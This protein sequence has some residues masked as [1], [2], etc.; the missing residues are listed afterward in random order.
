MKD[1]RLGRSIDF[2]ILFSPHVA[3]DLVAAGMPSPDVARFLAPETDA[4]EKWRML[5]PYWPLIRFTGYAQA[6]QRAARD[7]YQVPEISGQTHAALTEALR[8]GNRPG[9]YR[10]ILQ[11]QAGIDLCL[12]HPLD[13]R[14][15]VFR[16][17]ADGRLFR[18]DLGVDAFLANAMPVEEL[19]RQ[20][21]L[22]VSSLRELLRVIDWCFARYGDRAVAI[23]TRCA[24]WRTLRFDDVSQGQAETLFERGY[25]AQEGLSSSETKALQDFLFHCCI[26]RAGDYRLPV[27]IHTGYPGGNNRVDMTRIRATDLV[28][29]LPQVSAGPAS[30]SSTWVTPTSTKCWRSPSTSATSTSICRRR[31]R[32]TPT[33]HTAS[34][35]S[36]WPWPPSTSYSPSAAALSRPRSPMGTPGW[37]GRDWLAP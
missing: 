24:E 36:G 33:R 22:T 32:W 7:L 37:R 25:V 10:R 16:E 18:Q 2:S 4:D 28:A 34:C 14:G 5:A 12:I 15:V 23:A 17:R 27:K 3:W 11:E 30:C 31:G 20:S 19:S 6:A 21:G 8:Q 29:A 13:G 35:A 1:A 9:V 26:Q